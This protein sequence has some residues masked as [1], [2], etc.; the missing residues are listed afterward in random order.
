MVCDL[1][2]LALIPS[3]CYQSVSVSAN[4]VFVVLSG[5]L[6]QCVFDVIIVSAG[7]MQGKQQRAETASSEDV[8]R[9]MY[10]N[11]LAPIALARLFMDR[12]RTPQGIL[13]FMSS[14]QGSITQN[15]SGG[16][17]LYRASKAAL[18]S[19]TRSLVGELGR[20]ELTVLSLHPGWV[21]TELAGPH[22]PLDVATSVHGLVDAMLARRGS[23]RHAFVDYAGN[24][25]P[26]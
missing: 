16:S 11:A 21:R 12:L 20:R 9:L 6:E 24:E 15:T 2:A 5:R 23:H 19:L 17:E 4:L 13:G 26:W 7:I 10:T 25:I 3:R 8:V 22:A 1:T 14:S 18:N